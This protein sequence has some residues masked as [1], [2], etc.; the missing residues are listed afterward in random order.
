MGSAVFLSA[1]LSLVFPSSKAEKNPHHPSEYL[2][3]GFGWRWLKWKWRASVQYFKSSKAYELNIWQTII[4]LQYKVNI[5][6]EVCK[7]MGNTTDIVN[8]IIR[9]TNK[10]IFYE[11]MNIL[12]NIEKK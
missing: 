2:F 12:I 5:K 10:I 7:D 6:C 4:V 9:W 1:A 8:R 11:F 3:C